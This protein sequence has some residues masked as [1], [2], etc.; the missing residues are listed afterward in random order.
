MRTRAPDVVTALR[1]LTISSALAGR[2]AAYLT[3]QLWDIK[4][5]ARGGPSVALM[6][7][8]VANL[9][10]GQIRDIAAYLASRDP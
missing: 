4:T 10:P 3:R 6:Q 9:E 1:A 2:S 5:G 7:G 8:V